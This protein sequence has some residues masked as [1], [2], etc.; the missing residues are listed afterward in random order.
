MKENTSLEI[1]RNRLA[2]I[3]FIG[4]GVPFLI[5]VV[6]SIL[7]KYA[8]KVKEAFTWFIPTVFPTL[9]LMISVIGAAALIPK[10]NRVIRTS[11]LKLTV[12]VSI[13]YLV[14]LS[15]V[16]FLQ[17]FGNFED[18]IELFSMSNFF[19]TPIQGVVVAAL[20]FLFTS[21]Q[22]RDKPE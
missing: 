19:I 1:A 3:W 22:P 18:P 20:G 10:E 2:K 12:G 5:L 21:D 8:D 11:F 9:T 7:G 15:L 17:P 4:S 14:I 6:Q 13:A 16:L